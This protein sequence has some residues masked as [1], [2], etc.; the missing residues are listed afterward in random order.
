MDS[1]SKI[2]VSAGDDVD[3][4]AEICIGS[5]AET[6]GNRV[7]FWLRSSRLPQRLFPDGQ[8]KLDVERCNVDTEDVVRIALSD[9]EMTSLR[10]F[11]DQQD[12]IW[13]AVDEQVR[14][15]LAHVPAAA[16]N[17]ASRQFEV[18][19][20]AIPFRRPLTRA[21]YD[22]LLAS[23]QFSGVTFERAA[24]DRLN[25]YGRSQLCVT[26]RLEVDPEHLRVIRFR[27]GKVA[28]YDVM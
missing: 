22:R 11:V 16:G 8:V 5:L 6:R 15:E 26:I 18:C 27:D 10:E 23:G 4:I 2:E 1:S 7:F 14:A 21:K 24:Q 12:A 28:S 13:Q 9:R 17:D 3:V 19:E 20:V 25:A